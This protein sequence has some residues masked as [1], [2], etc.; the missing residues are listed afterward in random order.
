MPFG[1]GQPGGGLPPA[2]ASP[3]PGAADSHKAA[4][5][6]PGRPVVRTRRAASVRED[7]PD[8]GSVLPRSQDL[9]LCCPH[10]SGY[11]AGRSFRRGQRE[12]P[13]A[14]AATSP[15]GTGACGRPRPRPGTAVRAHAAWGTAR[16]L[17]PFALVGG[18]GQL[19]VDSGICSSAL[20]GNEMIVVCDYGGSAVT[21]SVKG[22]TVAPGFNSPLEECLTETPGT[23]PQVDVAAR[24]TPARASGRRRQGR[25]G[26][27]AD[28]RRAGGNDMS[29]VTRSVTHAVVRAPGF[30]DQD[31]GAPEVSERGS[32]RAFCN[33]H[34]RFR[35]RPHGGV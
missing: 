1:R 20:T 6:P 23:P 4:S 34:A 28:L 22:F 15:P 18:A 30:A 2:G 35:A 31:A 33:G 7:G 3:Y 21:R 12:Q 32:M 5:S 8:Q 26:F 13:M 19:M 16:K 14:P 9:R 29:T 11:P 27:E 10:L 24:A 25:A 17:T